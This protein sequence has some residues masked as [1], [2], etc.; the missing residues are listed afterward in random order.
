MTKVEAVRYEAGRA[1]A[2]D[3]FVSLARNGHFLFLRGY[4]DYH[5]DRFP[6]ASLMFYDEG[7]R[8]V[9]LLPA[10]VLD[11]GVVASH[12][13][14]TFGGLVS[15][16][17]TKAGLTLEIFDAM[18]ARLCADGYARL[19]YK[20]VP[21]IYHRAPCEED[22]YALFRA[23][24]RL[25]RRDLS[26]TIDMRAR[27]PFSKGRKYSI[28]LAAKSGVEVGP[29]DDFDAFMAIEERVLAER[30]GARPVHT[31]AE[32]RML[33]RRFPDNIKLFAASRGGRML[34][35][36]VVYESAQVAHAQYIGASPEGREV[37]AAD[38]I[39]G[40]LVE[41]LY[42]EKRFFDFGI[43]TERAGAYLNEGLAENKQGFGARA[44]VYD[45]YELEL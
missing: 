3:E 22:L 32:L 7:G 11:G 34:A 5:A 31:A 29:S 21:H 36:V 20:A 6:D 40:S 18:L 1:R 43:S 12:A 16:D 30:H 39:I 23:G 19:V 41:G 26:S 42:A 37:G 25:V 10:T 35:G 33:A 4:M 14:L 24:A 13:G 2:W 45:F 28:K 9:G 38:L 17:A 27:L 15:S 8:P 44:V